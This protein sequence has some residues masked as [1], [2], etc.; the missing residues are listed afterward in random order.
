[1]K[2]GMYP[3][4]MIPL[5][6]LFFLFSSSAFS[7]SYVSCSYI[8]DF[9]GG[10]VSSSVSARACDLS[11]LKSIAFYQY[12][13]SS[14]SLSSGY[15]SYTGWGSSGYSTFCSGSYT[16]EPVAFDECAEGL[17]SACIFND[18]LG[19]QFVPACA[20]GEQRNADLTCSVYYPPCESD[21]LTSCTDPVSGVVRPAVPS[22]CQQ[23][24]YYCNWDSS[25]PDQW[26]VYPVCGAAFV[27]QQSACYNTTIGQVDYPGGSIDV[28]VDAGNEYLSNLPSEPSNPGLNLTLKPVDDGSFPWN[29]DS[30]KTAHPELTDGQ[31]R[32]ESYCLENAGSG[33]CSEYSLAVD[34][35]DYCSSHP[36]STACYY[37]AP[38]NTQP[39]SN[40]V[41]AK[42]DSTFGTGSKSGSGGGAGDIS[43]PNPAVTNPVEGSEPAGSTETTTEMKDYTN[44][45]S[46]M[47]AQ[48][49]NVKSYLKNL[50]DWLSA[51]LGDTSAH[52]DLVQDRVFGN[53]DDYKGFIEALGGDDDIVG[54]APS[55]I[56]EIIDSFTPSGQCAQLSVEQAGSNFNLLTDF[57]DKWDNGGGRSALGFFFYLLTAAAIFGVWSSSSKN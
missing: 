22:E 15:C 16:S 56:D 24:G 38:T 36:W 27:I 43:T 26:A 52:D 6:L 11:A 10:T 42:A 18:P 2:R 4:G 17:N 28:D 55:K 39:P 53:Q 14:Y 31:S 8:K 32:R 46:R 37:Q 7:V 21:T 45:F 48:L 41:D 57:C 13:G 20:D 12:N 30:Y 40:E 9:T 3:W 33:Y 34:T 25:K 44:W 51:D 47:T 19:V 35:P 5:F 23:Q 54:G 1:M 49:D 29:T 50:S